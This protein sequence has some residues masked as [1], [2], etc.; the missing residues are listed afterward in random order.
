M[1]H[2]PLLCGFIKQIA[3]LKHIVIFGAGKS[4]T[5]LI[6]YL[7]QQL[8]A[9]NWSLT[10]LD[11]DEITAQAKVGTTPN[12]KGIGIDVQNEQERKQFIKS[13]GLVISLSPPSLHY[14]IA[15]RLHRI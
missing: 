4:S 3:A 7:A 11:A 15:L 13:A 5:F 12:A 6:G 9:N 2:S 1:N 8:N 14:L 10:V